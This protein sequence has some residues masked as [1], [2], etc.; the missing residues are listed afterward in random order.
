[1]CILAVADKRRVTD[2]ELDKMELANGDGA[3]IAWREKSRP[4]LEFPDIIRWEKG[5][6]LEEIKVFNA[7]APLPYVVH[8]RIASAGQKVPELTHLFPV[9]R[10]MRQVLT[11]AT[12]G[13][14]L[15]HNGTWGPYKEKGLDGAIRNKVRVPDG[16]WSDTRVMAWLAHLHGPG[17]LNL[18]D[19]K[20]ILFG[21]KKIEIFRDDL[22]FRVN[23]LIV[24]NRIWEHFTPHKRW[25]APEDDEGSWYNRHGIGNST[26]CRAQ[27]CLV[28]SVSGT[29]YC[30]EHQLECRH[31]DCKK[32]RVAGTETCVDHQPFC[33]TIGCNKPQIAGTKF[34]VLH[35]TSQEQKALPAAPAVLFHPRLQ[36]ESRWARALNPKAAR[37][38]PVM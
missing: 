17:I 34:C 35:S 14:V 23:D 24:S 13:F 8:F 15:F 29:F 20:I 1:M 5:L 11:G 32:P 37:V 10:D 3:G 36:E 18:I 30:A 22:W 21:P 33:T 16:L 4:D 28:E 19:E 25:V 12:K 31:Y 27:N 2:A 9:E 7:E 6:N 38:N 26:L